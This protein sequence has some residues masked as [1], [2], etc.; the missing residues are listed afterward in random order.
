MSQDLDLQLFGATIASSSENEYCWTLG[1][2]DDASDPKHYLL[3]QRAKTAEE[4][5]PDF[6]G[7]GLYYEIDDQI[8]GFYGG[9][10]QIVLGRH[11]IEL[12][13]T[14]ALS[15]KHKSTKVLRIGLS[16]TTAEWVHF[17]E[18]LMRITEGMV[19]VKQLE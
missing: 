5:T 7:N 18:D 10:E 12:V 1:V 4:R 6:S 9:M 14:E 13:L 11:E 17:Q 19:E 8:G 16:I 15:K 2:A 3:I